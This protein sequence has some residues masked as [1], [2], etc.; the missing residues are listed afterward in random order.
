MSFNLSYLWDCLVSG[1]QYIHIS[2][3]LALVPLA[4]GTVFGTL[5]ALSR[6]FHVRFVARFFDIVIPI[7]NGVPVIVTLFIY[8]LVYLIYCKPS[9]GG[10]MYVALFTFCLGDTMRLAETI[11]GA[12][13]SVP[14]GQYEA[15]YSTGLTVFQALRRVIIPQVI[16][17]AIPPFTNMTVGAI[18]NSSIVL[19]IGI[20]DVLN[21]ATMPC[22]N[23]YS[24]LEGYVA[25]AIIYWILNIIA[26][27]LFKLAERHSLRYKGGKN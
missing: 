1:A 17:A 8:N 24:F 13:L 21:G 12:F 16:P 4:V 2:L 7:Y 10:I 20:T 19:A 5:I 18:K 14:K 6:I 23:T 25:A 27:N 3:L 9:T 15:C 22:A 26:E 11:R